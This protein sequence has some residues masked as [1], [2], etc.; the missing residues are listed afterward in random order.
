MYLHTS[1]ADVAIL[2]RSLIE[3]AVREI[4]SDT[5]AWA[6]ARLA[7]AATSWVRDHVL[8]SEQARD[9]LDA[10]LSGEPHDQALRAA[11]DAWDAGFQRAVLSLRGAV[12]RDQRL[13]PGATEVVLSI[14]DELVATAVPEPLEHAIDDIAERLRAVDESLSA[15]ASTPA[16]R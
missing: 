12:E 6:G 3:S 7:T 13:H 2:A 14:L 5:R 1:I 11:I 9:D 10:L 4:A 8:D 15:A 16:H